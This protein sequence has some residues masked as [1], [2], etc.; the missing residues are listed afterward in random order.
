[1]ITFGPASRRGQR[2]VG[3]TM[4]RRFHRF[5]DCLAGWTDANA[6]AMKI[7]LTY[8]LETSRILCFEHFLRCT[9]LSPPVFYI[10]K[11]G[12]HL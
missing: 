7:R 8:L 3:E 9:N 4:F 5:V 11:R 10:N 2:P 1:M 6:M 12:R